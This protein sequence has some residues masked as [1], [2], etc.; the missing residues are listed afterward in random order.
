VKL[1]KERRKLLDKVSGALL[2]KE[3]LDRDDFEKIVG[4]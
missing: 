3:T 1:I 2:E 4:K